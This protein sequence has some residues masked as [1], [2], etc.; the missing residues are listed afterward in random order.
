MKLIDLTGL[1]EFGNN[2][3]DWVNAHFQRKV[4]GKGLSTYDYDATAKAKVDAIPANP[5]YTDTTYTAG[6]GINIE[7]NVISA[8]GGGGG[9]GGEENVIEIVKVN[10]TALTPDSD[11]A[12]D[13][14]VPT[15]VSDLTNDSGFITSYTE[16]DPT[17]PSWAKASSKPSYTASE[18]GAVPTTRTVNGKALSSNITLSASDV[19]ALPS[20]TVIPSEVT[21]STVAGWGFTKNTGTYSKPSGGIPKT[22]LASAVQTSLGKADTALQ[23]FTEQDPVFVASAAHGITSTDISNWNNKGTYSKPS[24]GIPDSDIAS[25]STWNAKYTKPSTGIPASD[26][27]SGVIPSVPTALSSFTDDL[28]SSPTHTHSQYLTSHQDISGKADKVVYVDASTPPSTMDA[29]KVYQYGTLSGNTT[30]PAFTAVASG[31]TAVKIWCWTFTTPS[32]APTITWPAGITGC[33][34][35]DAPTINAS[36][37]YE[38]NVMDGLATIIES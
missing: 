19:N 29:N 18:V 1:Q 16:T 12:V 8:T 23:S 9:G 28:G 14:E 24:G 13:V 35:G 7:N 5:K 11:K 3:R 31:D 33:S 22:D 21:E 2:V 37:N 32:T 17:V 4:D 15:K 25:A 20:S 27:A 30:F 38:V 6:N 10:G 36:K 26:L 34:G